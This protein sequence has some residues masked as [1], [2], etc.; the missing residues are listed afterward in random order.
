MLKSV[1]FKFGNFL[2][3]KLV[4]ILIAAFTFATTTVVGSILAGMGIGVGVGT[5]IEKFGPTMQSKNKDG[6]EGGLFERMGYAMNLGG[7]AD[8]FRQNQIDALGAVSNLTAKKTGMSQENVMS[9]GTDILKGNIS[10]PAAYGDRK[11][12]LESQ[13]EN[14]TG[15]Q[16]RAMADAFKEAS[17]HM[18]PLGTDISPQ[19]FKDIFRA[20]MVAAL[21]DGEIPQMLTKTANNTEVNR[22]P[23][24]NS[25]RQHRT[26]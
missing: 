21:N 1:I 11:A 24:K 10:V 5:L 8:T 15:A 3:G 19:E 14:A 12:M 7:G 13:V 2:L 23:M 26:Q 18:S 17:F 20:G 9:Q 22:S 4:N 25:S 16:K 6:F